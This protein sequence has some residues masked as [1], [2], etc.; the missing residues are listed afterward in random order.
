MGKDNTGRKSVREMFA[1]SSRMAPCRYIPGAIEHGTHGPDKRLIGFEMRPFST[2]LLAHLRF[3][4]AAYLVLLIALLPTAVVHWRV[5]KNVEAR[6]EA[7]FNTI[8][9]KVEEAIRE[10]LSGLTADLLAIGGFFEA[11]GEVSRDEWNMFVAKLE[12]E[13]R[14]PGIRS[15]GFAEKVPAEAQA[16]FVERVRKDGPASYDIFPPPTFP[17]AFPT[18]YVTQ[19]PTNVDARLGWDS[20]S[21]AQRRVALDFVA[22]TGWPSVTG[23]TLYWSRNQPETVGFTIFVPVWAKPD[24]GASDARMRGVVF[25][26]FIPQ[27][28]FDT[29]STK[30]FGAAVS[31]KL[32]DGSTEREADLLG[33]FAGPSS[34]RPSFEKAAPIILFGHVFLLRVT[35]RPEFEALSEHSLPAAVLSCGLAFSFLLFGIAWTQGSS[36]SAAEKLNR[37]LQQSEDRFRT[38]NAELEQK[39]AEAKLTEGLLAYERDLLRMLLEHSPDAIYFKDCDGRFIKCGRAIARHLGMESAAEAV[40]KTDF[41]FFTEEH[42]RPAFDC[43]QEIIRSGNPVIGLV[44]KETW[45]DGRETWVLTSKMPL[46]DKAGNIIG[47]FGITKDVTKLKATEL[48]LAKEKELLAVTLRSIGDAVITTDVDG[49]IVLFNRVAEQVTGWPQTD[50]IGKPLK[51]VFHTLGAESDTEIVHRAM[52]EVTPLPSR[53]AILV[54]RDGAERNISESVAP[55]IDQ[56]GQKIGAVLVFRDVT[57]KLKTEAELAKASKLESIG[58]LAGGIAHDFNNILT[59]ILGNISLARMAHGAGLRVDESLAEAENASLRARELTHRLLTFAK[60]GAPI[61][62]PLDLVPLIRDCAA[63]AVQHTSIIP[64]FFA[65]KDLWAV[66]ADESQ[67]AQ[68]ARNIISYVCALT[69]DDPRLEIHVFN[70]E[71]A[72]DALLLLK[73]GKYVR[74]SVRNYGTSIQPENVTKIFEPYFGSK[75][76]DSGL[77]LASAYSIVR[78]HEGQIRVESISGAGTIFHI[79]LPATIA[80]PVVSRT[81]MSQ[82][83]NSTRPSL[84]VL[85]MDDELSIRKLTAVLLERIGCTVVTAA[86]GAEAIEIY[87]TARRKGERFDVII[88][89]LTVPRGLGG[90]ELI[91]QLRALDPDVLAIV[92]SGYSNDPVMANFRDYGFAGV[93]PKP[94]NTA[95]LVRALDDLFSQGIDADNVRTA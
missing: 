84:R 35:S 65:G 3:R 90:K 47:T 62:K 55:I 9:A 44:E 42:A 41:D 50:A 31:A 75:K 58:V 30:E 2:R 73:P 53:E 36:R 71:V 92:S 72:N 37:R 46:R 25:S 94:Y 45:P 23:R 77:E 39:I 7:R 21:E 79:Y 81:A 34:A 24:G 5:R 52:T 32:F 6:D 68:V 14:H 38:A 91:S 64:E 4:A 93:V 74:I 85:V 51:Q 87:E 18:V 54:K 20:Y 43:E 48:A 70:Q 63:R 49:R 86:D 88:M 13:K 10:N 28:M 11:G 76:Q 67:I 83:R 57:E 27:Q 19:Y 78:K 33:A 56:R 82:A 8:V 66:E 59:V 22:R 17:I 1:F 80:L 16:R 26:S 12:L 95:D 60:G 69:T 29:F 40:G 89:D 15:V 61:K